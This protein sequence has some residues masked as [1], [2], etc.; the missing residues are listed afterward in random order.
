MT[1]PQVK[2]ML[3]KA[4]ITEVRGLGRFTGPLKDNGDRT[5]SIDSGL[6]EMENPKLVQ[7]FGAAQ[8]ESINLI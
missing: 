1:D 3:G 7:R 5:Y 2:T 8:I 6:G 4:A